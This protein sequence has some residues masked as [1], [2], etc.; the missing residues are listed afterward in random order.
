VE[1]LPR[2]FDPHWQANHGGVGAGLGL[3]IA[4]W[5]VEAHGGR[6]AAHRGRGGGLTVAFTIP[7]LP[8]DAPYGG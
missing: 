8:A 2:L 1:E 6:I 5:L 3:V 7:L 4:K